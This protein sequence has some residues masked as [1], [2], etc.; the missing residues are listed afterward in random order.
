MQD[1]SIIVALSHDRLQGYAA[2]GGPNLSADLLGRYLNN[3]SVSTALYPYFHLLEVV[4]RNR[5]HGA[6]SADQSIDPDLPNLYDQYP[7]WLDA[8][9]PIL[10]VHHQQL[11][12]DARESVHADLRR[13]FGA[14]MAS[15]KRLRTP[16]RLVAELSFSF[17]VFLFDEEY[18]GANRGDPGRLWP[19]YFESV[20]PYRNGKGSIAGIRKTLRRLLTVRNRIMHYERI[21][22]WEDPRGGVLN[23]RHIRDDAWTLIEWMEPAVAAPMKSHLWDEAF[24]DVYPRHLRLLARTLL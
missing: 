23:P 17:W 2:K 1:P 21:A 12:R 4:L 14:T 16:G 18:V 15:A 5:I 24:D 3:L 11:V 10:E 19:R 22:P 13:R 9:P 8:V 7:C 20:F 6:I